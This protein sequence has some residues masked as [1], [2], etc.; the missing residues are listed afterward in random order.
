MVTVSSGATLSISS[1]A[2]SGGVI[3]AS[4]GTLLVLS[5]G[6][7]IATQN[8][9]SVLVASGGVSIDDVTAS[10]FYVSL[11]ATASFVTATAGALQAAGTVLDPVIM[12]GAVL[13][14]RSGSVETGATILS[15]G[16]D[17]FFG[18]CV[19]S[20][21]LDATI[22]G[23]TGTAATNLRGGSGQNLL[24]AGFGYGNTTLIGGTG[25]TFA[26]A[27]GSGAT[28]IIGG[29]GLTEMVGVTGAGSE[30]MQTGAGSAI[31]G[32]NNVADLVVGG[33][34][35]STVIGGAGPDL[36]AFVAG[37]AGGSE[38]ILNFKV[39]T[40]AVLFDPGYG[41]HAV[42]SEMITTVAGWGKSDVVT[43]A[44]G[45]ALIFVNVGHKMFS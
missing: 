22:F 41:S 13:V 37:H 39:G 38:T 16:S 17:L 36:Y 30:A 31:I 12:S 15:G 24:I 40:D 42:A 5:G 21:D 35:Q 43:L 25:P 14:M 29:T 9:Q 10:L 1:G 34:G 20:G 6:T 7:D 3:V 28:T 2:T 11:G 23:G 18:G 44:D 33:S 4:G 27:T 19:A 26:F 45:T 32:L 8:S